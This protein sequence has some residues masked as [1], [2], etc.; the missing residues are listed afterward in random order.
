MRVFGIAAV[1]GRALKVLCSAL[2]L[3]VLASNFWTMRNWTERTGVWDDICYLRQAHLFERFGLGGFDTNIT[4]DDDGYFATLEREVGYAD[5]ADP[6]LAVCHTTIGEKRVI[7]YPPGTG[8]AL[9]IFPAGFQRVPLYAL[10][11]VLIF[12]AAVISIWS[13]KS[14]N[15]IVASALVGVA[16]LYFMI[17]PAKASFSIAPTMMICVVVGYLSGVMMTASGQR[18][19]TVSALVGLLLGLAVSIRLANLFLS[20]GYFAVLFAAV[21]W[22]RKPDDV[23]RLLAFGAAYL[24]GLVPALVANAIN[25]GSPLA[26]TYSSGDAVPPDFS[27]SITREYLADMQGSLILMTLAWGAWVLVS[28]RQNTISKIVVANLAIN[29][30]FFLSH[31]VFTP[32]YLMPIAMLS[33]WTLL[34]SGNASHRS[35]RSSTAD[36]RTP[37]IGSRPAHF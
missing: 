31:A 2:C 11:N 17:N 26:T 37:A 33:L 35:S 8:F 1:N 5:W 7:Q 3:I 36:L 24:I 30:L 9:S 23:R 15:W 34:F 14:R 29:L 25:A 21:V 32:Y 22:S 6:A 4:R 19:L 28:E 16:A 20:G 18:L 10:A 13:A 27:F 12:L